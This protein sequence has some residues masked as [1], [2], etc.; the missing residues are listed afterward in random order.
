[1]KHARKMVLVDINTIK[2]TTSVRPAESPAKNDNALAKAINSLVT[3]TEFSKTNYGSSAYTIAMLDKEMKEILERRD[4]G[5]N[6]RLNIYNQKLQK[7][8]FLLRESEK[9]EQPH[10]RN[11]EI[12]PPGTPVLQIEPEQPGAGSRNPFNEVVTPLTRQPYKTHLPRITP[13]QVRLRASEKRQKSSRLNNF[14]SNWDE[15]I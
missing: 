12:S 2:P 13:K 8:L 11:N 6:E 5:P 10:I 15:Y 7:Y 14:L 4:L 9:S 1:M 3:S